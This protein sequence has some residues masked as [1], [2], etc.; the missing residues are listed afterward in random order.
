MAD[1][2]VGNG[3]VKAEEYHQK[4]LSG[5]SFSFVKDFDHSDNEE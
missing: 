5:V 3:N 2:L 4:A 1:D